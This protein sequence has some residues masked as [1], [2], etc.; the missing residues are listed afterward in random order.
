MF[1]VQ[2]FIVILLLLVRELLFLIYKHRIRVF[3]R[4]NVMGIQLLLEY[5]NKWVIKLARLLS[6]LFILLLLRKFVAF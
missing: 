3:M 5:A 4:K 1:S 2:F 6:V